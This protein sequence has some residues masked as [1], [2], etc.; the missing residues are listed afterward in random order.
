MSD[1]VFNGPVQFDMKVWIINDETEQKATVTI[2]LGPFEFPTAET[3]KA[4]LEELEES[5]FDGKLKGFR[6]MNKQE[7]W[8]QF[9]ADRFGQRLALPGAGGVQWDEIAT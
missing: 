3:I 6:L 5:E 9:C 7:A 1:L 4:H 2:S 8:D